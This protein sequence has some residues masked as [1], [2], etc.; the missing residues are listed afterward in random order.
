MRVLFWKEQ[1]V[2]GIPDTWPFLTP[3]RLPRV[4]GNS[5]VM[6]LSKG[7]RPFVQDGRASLS[8]FRS[9]IGSGTFTSP[10]LHPWKP[11]GM[12]FYGIFSEQ[13]DSEARSC[14][15]DL[16]LVVPTAPWVRS[17][18][19]QRT[20]WSECA[21][22]LTGLPNLSDRDHDRNRTGRKGRRWR[23]NS[24]VHRDCRQKLLGSGNCRGCVRSA[25][26][27]SSYAR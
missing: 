15:V 25:V 16:E 9:S 18:P 11:D 2:V 13:R 4:T 6:R 21:K 20:L 24:S 7:C 19:S 27:T 22:G 17:A 23:A 12:A 8:D 3:W 10:N 1:H 14:A 5:D 26:S